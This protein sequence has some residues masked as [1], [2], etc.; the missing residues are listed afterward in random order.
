M[1]KQRPKAAAT[2]TPPKKSFCR[3]RSLRSKQN[4]FL[5][6][7][8]TL[9]VKAQPTLN[10]SFVSKILLDQNKLVA[11]RSKTLAPQSAIRNNRRF[12][13]Q[14]PKTTANYTAHDVRTFAA[15]VKFITQFES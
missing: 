5:R 9:H 2:R 1:A 10:G 6:P 4:S 13:N 11:S 14:N 3:E 8:A 15:H 12:S 7:H